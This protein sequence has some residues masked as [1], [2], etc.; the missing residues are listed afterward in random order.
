MQLY[1]KHLQYLLVFDCIEQVISPIQTAHGDHVIEEVN[2]RL[3]D[4]NLFVQFICLTLQLR[5]VFMTLLQWPRET[6]DGALSPDRTQ[7]GTGRLHF[8]TEPF[9]R[10]KTKAER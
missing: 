8:L 9:C 7:V 1:A 6:T 5:E 2:Q 3:G 4:L 10:A